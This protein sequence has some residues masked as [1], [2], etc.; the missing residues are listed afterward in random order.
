MPSAIPQRAAAST[1]LMIDG[2]APARPDSPSLLDCAKCD[3]SEEVPPHE[4]R[5][6]NDRRHEYEGAGRDLGPGQ[7]LYISLQSSEA[8]RDGDGI[9]VV[10]C[11]RESVF[12]PR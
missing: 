12:I 11:Q 7:P 1:R 10:Q 3:P 9:G 2:P 5:E 8:D 4:D 6:E